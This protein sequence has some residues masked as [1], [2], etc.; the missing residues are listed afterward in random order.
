MWFDNAY[1][2]SSDKNETFL[3][4]CHVEDIYMLQISKI[5]W[6]S[7]THLSAPT[8]NGFHMKELGQYFLLFTC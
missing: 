8:S 4:M 3:E 6:I 2:F 1:D 7:S 5:E